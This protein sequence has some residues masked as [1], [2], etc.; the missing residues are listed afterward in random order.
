VRI[1]T[2]ASFR[3]PRGRTVLVRSGDQ[4]IRIVQLPITHVPIAQTL[5][6]LRRRER[7]PFRFRAP[8]APVLLVG[9][10]FVTRIAS[11]LSRHFPFTQSQVSSYRKGLPNSSQDCR[12]R[13]EYRPSAC[14]NTPILPLNL[15]QDHPHLSLPSASR[16]PRTNRQPFLRSRTSATLHQRRRN[17]RLRAIP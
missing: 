17:A 16:G 1:V 13:F 8:P 7:G 2:N 4:M 5:G 12:S 15:G 11:C 6:K 9:G 10:C 14:S 3:Q